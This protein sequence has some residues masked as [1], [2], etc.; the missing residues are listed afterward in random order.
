MASG[1]YPGRE[2]PKVRA[3]GE[4]RQGLVTMSKPL[5]LDSAI[6]IAASTLPTGYVLRVVVERGAGWLELTAP[7]G[8]ELEIPG[9]PKDPDS[10]HLVT[11]YEA[12][13]EPAERELVQ[14]DREQ[15]IG[16]R[17]DVFSTRDATA[18]GF[19]QCNFC[20]R[21]ITLAQCRTPHEH[22]GCQ[23]VRVSL[24]RIFQLDD[25]AGVVLS[26]KADQCVFIVAT[27]FV[28]SPSR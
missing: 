6:E 14:R 26:L 24:Q 22:V 23:Q 2:L 19:T 11:L 8:D 13:A 15:E 1:P 12:F 5:S 17:Y 4:L 3:E 28:C 25:C 20:G 27:R 10:A 16:Q 9:E 21:V 7:N 18:L